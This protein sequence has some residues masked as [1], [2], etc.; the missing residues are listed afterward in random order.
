MQIN[1]TSPSFAQDSIAM[2]IVDYFEQNQHD[3]NIEEATLYYEF[4]LFKEIDEDIEYPTIM[5]I[6]PNHGIFII[7]S[8]DR[9]SRT[10]TSS[11]SRYLISVTEQ[12]YSFVYS[13]LIKVP[14]LRTKRRNELIFSIETILFMP[15][16]P[17]FKVPD[18]N[19][20]THVCHSLNEFGTVF[21]NVLQDRISE[22]NLIDILSVIEG[23]RGFPKPKDRGIDDDTKFTKG[24]LLEDLEREIARFDERQKLAALTQIDGP[25]RVRGLAGSG[26]TVV[27]AMK[28]ALIH[29]RNPEAKILYTFYT[30]SL[31]DIVRLLITRFYRMHED[32]DP[33]WDKI[34]VRHAWGG[35]SLPGVYYDACRV[36]NIVPITFSE[37][38][39][40]GLNAFDFV[41]QDLLS[42]TNGKPQK[43]Y[44]YILLDEGQDFDP[45][46]YWIC[47]AIVKNDCIVWAYDE[48]QNILN[49]EIQNPKEVF[50]NSYGYEGIDLA[51]LQE[52]YPRQN[53][54]IVL[55]KC[56][57]NPKEILVVANAVGFGIY[58]NHILQ[59][60]ENKEHWEDLGYEV[61]QGNCNEGEKTIIFR[62]E[63]NSPS[64][65]SQKQQ[66]KELIIYEI[67][68]SMDEEVDWVCESIIEDLNENLLPEDIL[69]ISLDNRY[70]RRYFT[71]ISQILA[72]K[73][74]RTNN[75]LNSYTGDDF[76][77]EGCITLST[78][79]RAKGNEA[80]M[81]YVIGADAFNGYCKDD[82]TERNKL[83][84]A[85]TRA[86]AWLRI[87]S[88]NDSCKFLFNEIEEAI[89]NLPSMKFDYPGEEQIKTL[90]RE[91]A[92]ANQN[93]LQKLRAF[94]EKLDELG[95]DPDEAIA[96]LQNRRKD[97]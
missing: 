20:E 8:D 55:H 95:I 97:K 57:R 43:V 91:L 54:D 44:D 2:Q 3:L 64:T 27:L 60:L 72:G 46:F 9:T 96:M 65:M 77:I 19:C 49:V 56:Y 39:R 13:K 35:K 71:K 75:I 69:V 67:N 85:L 10:L 4:P 25:Q 74:I 34:H 42:K 32:H 59:R 78:V 94:Q 47:R 63:K 31:Y 41:C 17:E 36:N 92:E 12:L 76:I 38:S 6:S 50:K 86:K 11:G 61:I 33:S 73:N 79:Y 45:S 18:D 14:S 82:I 80:A 30:K 23:T 84:T 28:A 66:A 88:A 24:G 48:L 1:I 90:R 7:K 21:E 29:M 70:A 62:P 68:E 52:R 53:N 5:I 40:S 26:K 89:G 15:N 83:F 81:V 16:Y 87:S 22:A 93:K 37:A 58:N 51:K